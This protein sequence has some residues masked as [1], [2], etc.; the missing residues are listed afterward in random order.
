MLD[1]GMWDGAYYLAGYAAQLALKAC[2]IKT[3]MAT[4][5]FPDKEFSKNCYTHGLLKLV[6]LA[7]LDAARGT[8]TASD[9][10][11]SANWGMVVGWT[12]DKRYHRI[13]STEA[14]SLYH[15]VADAPSGVLAW[16]KNYW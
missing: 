11:L 16:I 5:A 7:D 6:G 3:L 1:Q 9:A 10:V 12:E 2:I 14:R 4:D 13:T 15:A 8:A